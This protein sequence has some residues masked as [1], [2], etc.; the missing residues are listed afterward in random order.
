MAI[1]TGG[2]G[3]GRNVW[4]NRKSDRSSR[5]G[6]RPKRINSNRDH[7]DGSNRRAPSRVFTLPNRM[8]PLVTLRWNHLLA[9]LLAIAS[10]ALA[11]Y[12]T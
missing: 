8:A 6:K 11:A 2:A 12:R 9:I 3:N 5:D 1:S 4:G 10:I 7:R